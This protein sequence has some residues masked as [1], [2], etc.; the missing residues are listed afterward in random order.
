MSKYPPGSIFKTIVGLVALE[1]E[2]VSSTARRICKGGY[3]PGGP[4]T[5]EFGCHRHETQIDLP[6][7]LQ[8]SCNTYYWMTFRDIVDQYG[9]SLPDRGLAIFSRYLQRFGI[10]AVSYTHLTLPTILLV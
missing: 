3:R 6:K 5:R 9:E 2:I 8:H 1:E 10:G 4:G 7:S